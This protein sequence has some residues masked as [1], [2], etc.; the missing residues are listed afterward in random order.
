[1][2]SKSLNEDKNSSIKRSKLQRM[3]NWIKNDYK[4]LDNKNNEK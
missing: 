1:M 4:N 2:D 3:Q